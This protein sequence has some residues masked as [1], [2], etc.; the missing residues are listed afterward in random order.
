MIH[1]AAGSPARVADRCDECLDAARASGDD[2]EL[3]G[4]L[5][6]SIAVLIG[7]SRLREAR[8]HAEEAVRFAHASG[9]PTLIGISTNLLALLVVDEDTDR[10]RALLRESL[11]ASDH[12]WVGNMRGT[13]VLRLARLEGTLEDP[14]WARAFRPYLARV[15]EAGDRRSALILLESYSRALAEAGRPEVAGVLRGAFEGEGM[16]VGS[17][18][19]TERRRTEE[20]MTD[21]LGEDRLVELRR[22]GASM[23]F[24]EALG[25]ALAELDRVIASA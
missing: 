18:S 22:R 9:S 2:F 11:A 8:E 1:V 21:A 10:A 3:G 5:I 15:R 4:S 20:L 24:D 12:P 19:E 6:P 16:L 13:A 17:V 7:A 23:S 25:V 14:E